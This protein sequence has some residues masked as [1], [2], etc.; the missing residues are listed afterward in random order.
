MKQIV[1]DIETTGTNPLK[2]RIIEIAFIELENWKF[3]GEFSK[4]INPK[5][6][7]P[8]KAYKVHG[9]SEKMLVDAVS[10]QDISDIV[11]DKLSNAIVFGYRC[12]RFDLKF[13]NYELFRANKLPVFPNVFDLSSLNQFFK[14]NSLYKIANRIGLDVKEKHRALFDAQITLKIIRWLLE[15]IG[16]K[17]IEEHTFRYEDKSEKLASLINAKTVSKILYRSKYKLSEHI[18]FPVDIRSNFVIFYN[19]VFD[20]LYKLYINRIVKIENE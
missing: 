3:L 1:I 8:K 13:I 6:E 7:I 2:D 4:L 15:N 10:F 9:I 5:V 14:A 16:E 17:I 12:L 19:V 20:K 11:R 18:G